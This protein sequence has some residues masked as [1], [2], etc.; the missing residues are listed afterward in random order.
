MFDML[1]IECLIGLVCF[2]GFVE[3]L[4]VLLVMG[5]FED[6]VLCVI[7]FSFGCFNED[8]DVVVVVEC[9]VYYFK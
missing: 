2:S 1:G 9:I 6:I 8:L 5:V 3:V 4:F 7:C